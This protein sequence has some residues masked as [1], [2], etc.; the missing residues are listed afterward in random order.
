V[1]IKEEK[2]FRRG[3]SAAYCSLKSLPSCLHKLKSLAM[4][5]KS[6]LGPQSAEMDDSIHGLKGLRYMLNFFLH[7]LQLLQ[8]FRKSL[9]LFFRLPFDLPFYFNSLNLFVVVNEVI[10]ISIIIIDDFYLIGSFI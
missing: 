3:W 1:P 10:E 4:I 9:I 5:D 8:F 7:L 6:Q 2:P